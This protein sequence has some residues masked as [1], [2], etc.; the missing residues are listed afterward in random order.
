[1]TS[2]HA[3]L[4][5]FRETATSGGSG[6]ARLYNYIALIISERGAEPIALRGNQE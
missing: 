5:R 2:I 3:V 1:M 4:E 6:K